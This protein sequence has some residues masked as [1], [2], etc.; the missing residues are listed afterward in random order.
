[1]LI[2]SNKVI[3]IHYTLS[4]DAGKV[5]D[6]SVGHEPMA[7]LHGSGNIISGLE[8]ALEGRRVGDKIQVSIAPADG[9][10]ERDA[11]LLQQVPRRSLKGMG[12]IKTGMQLQSKTAHGMRVFSV[13]RIVGDMVTLD[14]NH[15]LAGETLHF[16]V[17]VTDIRNATEEEIA[18]GHI[19]GPGGHHH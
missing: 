8:R 5:I 9:Y 12:E 13:L 17:E 18:H 11:A 1:M 6:S 10:G 16:A 14:G 2:E 7:Y 19:H 4:N 15:P 3:S